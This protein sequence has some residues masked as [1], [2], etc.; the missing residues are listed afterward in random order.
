MFGIGIGI[1]Y[2]LVKNEDA[3]DPNP[4]IPAIEIEIE[5]SNDPRPFRVFPSKVHSPQ[6]RSN[7]H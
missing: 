5:S 2:V 4:I 3:T 7:T 1:D 6:E